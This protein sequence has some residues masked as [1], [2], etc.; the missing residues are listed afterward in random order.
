M[1]LKKCDLAQSDY[2][3]II[4]KITFFLDINKFHQ[5]FVPNHLIGQKVQS[6]FNNVL[7]INKSCRMIED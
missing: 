7:K 5:L 1:H 4:S 3:N 6:N 2:K